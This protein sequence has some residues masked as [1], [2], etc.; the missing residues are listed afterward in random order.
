MQSKAGKLFQQ[1][2]S[3]LERAGLNLLQRLTTF[4]AI[5]MKNTTKMWNVTYDLKLTLILEGTSVG[6]FI[7]AASNF[8]MF[9]KIGSQISQKCV[10]EFSNFSQKKWVLVH[11]FKKG[12]LMAD[13]PKIW[14]LEAT[15]MNLPFKHKNTEF[16]I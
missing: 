2:C 1:V 13:F 10:F 11:N 8:Q 7:R 16:S 3:K 14:K 6:E 15:Q 4:V 9:W 12:K 5:Y